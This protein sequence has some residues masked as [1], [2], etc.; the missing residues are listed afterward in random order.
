[1]YADGYAWT[2]CAAYASPP[3]WNRRDSIIA[4]DKILP[5]ATE[6]TNSNK[7]MFNSCGIVHGV[8][9]PFYS[10]CRINGLLWFC[11]MGAAIIDFFYSR[12]C[13]LILHFILLSPCS[14]SIIQPKKFVNVPKSKHFMN[15]WAILCYMALYAVISCYSV[16]SH[17]R[18]FLFARPL[19]PVNGRDERQCRH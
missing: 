4:C 6:P 7:T 9:F 14:Y 2:G 1:M 17:A 16:L 18:N 3:L 12:F 8:T 15:E 13:F 10:F 11:R 5:P 19:S